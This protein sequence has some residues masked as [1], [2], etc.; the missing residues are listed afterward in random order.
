MFSRRGMN[1]ACE[2]L[3]QSAIM[4]INRKV[5]CDDRA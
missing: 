1:E 3:A 4:L 2:F 5:I